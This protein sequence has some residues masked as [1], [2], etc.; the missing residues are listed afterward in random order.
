MVHLK[1]YI[2]TNLTKPLWLILS[3]KSSFFPD[4]FPIPHKKLDC[5][6]K[7]F[8]MFIFVELPMFLFKASFYR[9]QWFDDAN[10]FRE[11]MKYL[12]TIT[13]PNYGRYRE[14]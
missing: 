9:T 4:N 6:V 13:L 10:L 14:Q 11:K 3:L 8:S 5:F 7:Q 1:I 2:I 12:L